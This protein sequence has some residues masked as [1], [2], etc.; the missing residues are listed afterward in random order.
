MHTYDDL[1]LDS[2]GSTTPVSDTQDHA[3]NQWLGLAIRQRGVRLAQL[4]ARAGPAARTATVWTNCCGVAT[5]P[6]F[7]AAPGWLGVGRF[8]LAQ[9]VSTSS[10]VQIEEHRVPITSCV[11]LV[12]GE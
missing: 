3:V 9:V 8:V 1:G 11:R 7:T 2:R 4:G 12:G 6:S 5:D 10:V